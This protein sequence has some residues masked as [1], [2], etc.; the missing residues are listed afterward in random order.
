MTRCCS[1]SIK[2]AF[3]GPIAKL[4]QFGWCWLGQAIEVGRNVDALKPGDWVVPM[5]RRPCSGCRP[6][7]S[8]RPDLCATGEYVERGIVRLHG[9]FTDLAVDQSR[10]LLLVP[11][12]LLDCAILVEPMSAVEK[13]IET[14][15][16]AHV[17]YF[18]FDPPRALVLGAGAIGILAALTFPE[19]GLDLAVASLDDP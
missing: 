7:A 13:A 5:V 2:L 16:R 14:A 19:R 17:E 3:A 12:D 11:S 9:Y 4:Q 8:G 15:Q 6:C 1:A 10:Y 18:P